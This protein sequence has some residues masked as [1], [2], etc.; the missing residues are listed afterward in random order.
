MDELVR[1]LVPPGQPQLAHFIGQSMLRLLLAAILGGAIGVQRELRHKPAGLRTNMFICFGAAMF[2]VLSEALAG[3]FGGDHT[4]IAA[5]IIP[6]I[7]FIGAGSI[8]HDKR[9]ITGI[10]TAATIFVVASI[11]MAAGGGQTLLAIFA[12]VIVLISLVSLGY[13]EARWGLKPVAMTYDL[14]GADA[15]AMMAAINSTLRQEER[16]IEDMQLSTESGQARILITVDA[17]VPEHERILQ[18][19]RTLPA[20]AGSCSMRRPE[21]E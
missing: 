10:T 12:A 4:R 2:T 21:Q 5:Q 17:N 18:R 20:I 6:G 7:G 9:G 19:L 3:S 13:F 14:R 16:S 15:N 8:L 11:G 1:W